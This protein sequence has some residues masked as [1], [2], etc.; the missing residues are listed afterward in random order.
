MSNIKK[1]WDELTKIRDRR[2]GGGGG[3]AKKKDMG[4]SPLKC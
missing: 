2:I 4:K 3:G 1:E